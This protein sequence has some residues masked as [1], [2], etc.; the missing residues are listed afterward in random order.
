MK[1]T[2]EITLRVQIDKSE[3]PKDMTKEEIQVDLEHYL[4][5]AANSDIQTMDPFLG[6]NTLKVVHKPKKS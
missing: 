5:D 1:T 3:W 4:I 6:V 2:L